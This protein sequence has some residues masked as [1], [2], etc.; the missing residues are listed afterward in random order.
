MVRKICNESTKH[1]STP[2]T[3][4]VDERNDGVSDLCLNSD[5]NDE[6]L[7]CVRKSEKKGE[8]RNI[9]MM[10]GIHQSPNL[11][12]LEN[13]NSTCGHPIVQKF[14]LCNN[15]GSSNQLDLPS[16]E[17]DEDNIL[18][19]DEFDDHQNLKDMNNEERKKCRW[20]KEFFECLNKLTIHMIIDPKRQWHCPACKGGPGAIRWFTGLHS[21]MSHTKTKCGFKFKLHREL[22]QLLEEELHLRG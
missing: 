6:W 8:K 13:K 7:V 5:H 14:E 4:R 9:G 19:D 10:S 2:K 15:V 22:A 16:D 17:S 3:C 11:E 1:N 18:S 12:S 20:F 21:L